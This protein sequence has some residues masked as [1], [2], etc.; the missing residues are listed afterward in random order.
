[1]AV[2]QPWHLQFN[3]RFDNDINQQ[4]VR[5]AEAII[6]DELRLGTTPDSS[7]NPIEQ[8]L[9]AYDLTDYTFMITV[10]GPML[11]MPQGPITALSSVS[12]DDEAVDL[13]NVDV[14]PWSIRYRD[15]SSFSCGSTVSFSATIGWSDPADIPYRIKS[16]VDLVASH[17][18]EW[19]DED[20]RIIQRSDGEQYFNPRRDRVRELIGPL[21][22]PW[23]RPTIF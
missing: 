7:S 13:T 10:D 20:S 21:L 9:E 1:M 15:D 14:A 6:V 3:A 22:S 8:G 11:V 2:L 16:A 4:I 18:A 12:V 17:I 23:T 19:F 5:T